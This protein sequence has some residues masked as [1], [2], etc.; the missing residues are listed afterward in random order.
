VF[1]VT[2]NGALTVLASFNN[3]NGSSPRDGL[4]LG[5][6]G[7]FYGTAASGGASGAGTVF[8]MTPA[9][10][11][12]TLLSFSL[13]NGA[14]PIGGL[15]LG[16]DGFL[17]G[18]T[19][20]GGTNIG[21]GDVF[22]ISTNGNLTTLAR[23]QGTN[24]EEPAFRLT[25]GNDGRLY[26]TTSFGGSLDNSPSGI[27]SGSVF[28]VTTNGVFN[29]LFLFQGTN[30]S[31][32]MASLTLGPDGNLYGTTSIGGPGGGGTIFRVVLAPQFA[33]IA[34]RPNHRFALTAT[35]PSG[36]PLRL[37]TS[38][39]LATPVQFWTLVTNSAFD[40][41]GTFSYTDNPPVAVQGYYRLSTP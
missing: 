25:F 31:N 16:K 12:T 29:T 15:V 32:P 11:L 10:A 41:D 17:Y 6:D 37:W 2:T 4:I 30:G 23:F 1:Q 38:A 34:T 8:R 40:V 24:G 36:S 5:N 13:T 18:T 27:G 22:R 7:N 14:N 20:F 35:G 9:G 28:A 26:G 33:G 39:N 19:G 21:F 3:T